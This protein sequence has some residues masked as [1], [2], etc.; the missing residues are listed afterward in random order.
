VTER[1]I[2]AADVGGT[3]TGLLLLPASSPGR[4]G[5]PLAVTTNRSADFASLQA[6]LDAF[7]AAHAATA[8]PAAV[9]IGFAGAIADGRGEGTNVPWTVDA[10]AL[11]RH[12]GL[13]HVGLVN[14]LVATAYGIATLGDEARAPLLPGRSDPEGNAAVIAA[15]TGLGETTLARVGTE[16]VPVASE[17]GH[18]DFA[19]RTDAELDVWTAMRTRHGRVSVERVLSG[20]G[21]RNIAEVIH[22]RDGTESSWA[23]H[24]GEAGSEDNLPGVISRLGLAGS[25]ASCRESLDIFVGIYGAEAGNLALRGMATAGVYVGGG[26]APQILEAL[27]GPTFER[28]FRDKAPHEALLASIPVWVILDDRTALWGAARHASLSLR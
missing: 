5:A 3:K 16:L 9:T 15:G 22:A 28:A 8:S 13:P 18:A 7:L 26:I 6:M 17:G 23:A 14:D 19:P 27:K 25:C 10:G 21:L 4:L 11:A 1:F 12:F 2:L 24:H 20:P